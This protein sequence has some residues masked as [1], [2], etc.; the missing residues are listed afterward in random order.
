[1]WLRS[2]CWWL[3]LEWLRC[4]VLCFNVDRDGEREMGGM[5]C[6][7]CYDVSRAAAAL[8][9]LRLAVTMAAALKMTC[10]LLL[11]VLA[12]IMP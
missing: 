4:V 1:M 7:M 5:L 3:C 10:P 11:L 6:A 12:T 2:F 8:A 9:L